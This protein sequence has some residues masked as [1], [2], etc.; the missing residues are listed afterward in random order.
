MRPKSN[1]HASKKAVF[2]ANIRIRVIGATRIT[3]ECLAI[4]II[5]ARLR[6]TSEPM[7]GSSFCQMGAPDAMSA[8][9]GIVATTGHI[10]T[11]R[12]ARIAWAAT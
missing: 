2:G 9:M 3:R 12:I 5:N 11:E 1:V 10:T 6:R 7:A 4:G 8:A